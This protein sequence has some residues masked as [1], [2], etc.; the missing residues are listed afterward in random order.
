MNPIRPN[1]AGVFPTVGAGVFSVALGNM[2]QFRIGIIPNGE[3]LFVAVE[4]IGAYEFFGYAHRSYI[5]EKLDI[6]D[7]DAANLA[8]FINDQLEPGSQRQGYYMK[9]LCTEGL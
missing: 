3:G 5:E 8:D 7:G 1:Q 6:L 4:G 9:H 2:S